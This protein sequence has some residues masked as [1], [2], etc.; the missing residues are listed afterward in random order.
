MIETS[1]LWHNLSSYT[2][3]SH[4]FNKKSVGF[5]VGIDALLAKNIFITGNMV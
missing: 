1:T 5:G 4:I 2:I 3:I